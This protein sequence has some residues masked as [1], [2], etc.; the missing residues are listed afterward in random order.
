LQQKHFRVVWK[1]SVP[2]NDGGICLGQ[3]AIAVAMLEKGTANEH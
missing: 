1:K 3:A 2:V